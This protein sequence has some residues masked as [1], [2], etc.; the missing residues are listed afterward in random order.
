MALSPCHR[1]AGNDSII[2][3]SSLTHHQG[4][5]LL[6]A[7]SLFHQPDKCCSCSAE[8]AAPT[9][10]YSFRVSSRHTGQSGSEKGKIRQ[11]EGEQQ[12]R[13]NTNTLTEWFAE[14]YLELFY[15][16]WWQK[17]ATMLSQLCWWSYIKVLQ[18]DGVE[19]F[20]H[21]FQYYY[22]LNILD[23]V[24][25]PHLII[26]DHTALLYCCHIILLGLTK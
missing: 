7:I 12:K 22:R 4:S 24:L 15:T 21:C 17:H 2:P 19:W 11:V 16:L 20:I 14:E 13:I 18:V 10:K 23:T 8:V 25:K 9:D 5:G 1:S 6:R 3:S 26:F